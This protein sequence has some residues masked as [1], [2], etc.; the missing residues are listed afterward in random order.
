MAETLGL[1]PD[2]TAAREVLK[3]V[4]K[5][6][7]RNISVDRLDETADA[8]RNVL[9]NFGLL[10]HTPGETKKESGFRWVV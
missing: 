8:T 9:E 3:I 1:Y 2:K 6:L 4:G 7:N 10:E 5:V